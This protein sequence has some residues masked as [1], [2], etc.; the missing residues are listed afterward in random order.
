MHNGECIGLAEPISPPGGELGKGHSALIQKPY[1]SAQGA[2]GKRLSGETLKGLT[3]F[4]MN[5]GET[6]VQNFLNRYYQRQAGAIQLRQAELG[7]LQ[8]LAGVGQTA[9]TGQA[10]IA[11]QTGANVGNLLQ[12]GGEQQYQN[13]LAQ[14]NIA[15]GMGAGI[16]GAS[17]GAMQNYLDLLA[18]REKIGVTTP[19]PQTEGSIF[20]A[21]T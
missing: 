6:K 11:G 14:G 3:Q 15:T 5:Y 4:A 19:T 17:Q 8:S 21:R 1:E 7:P 18:I 20:P 2:R 12:T 9:A 16:A 13:A 10:A